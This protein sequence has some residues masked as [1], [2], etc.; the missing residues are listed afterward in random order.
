MCSL[1]DEI[2]L[3]RCALFILVVVV[4]VLTS[5]SFFVWRPLKLPISILLWACGSYLGRNNGFISSLQEK[6]GSV[7]AGFK[8]GVGEASRR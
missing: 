4:E 1:T 2:S 8:R 5:H 6:P 3:R 7:E